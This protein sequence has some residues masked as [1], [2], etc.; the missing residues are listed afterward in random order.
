MSIKKSPLKHNE[1]VPERVDAHDDLTQEQHDKIHGGDASAIVEEE[2]QKKPWEF[3][4]PKSD[5]ED[6]AQV[7]END[8]VV[9]DVALETDALTVVAPLIIDDAVID[10]WDME[11]GYLNL[12]D[13]VTGDLLSDPQTQVYQDVVVKGQDAEAQEE[14]KDY[15]AGSY[16]EKSTF[17]AKWND[18]EGNYSYDLGGVKVKHLEN[19]NGSVGWDTFRQLS[20]S[21]ETTRNVEKYVTDNLNSMHQAYK[22]MRTTEVNPNGFDN[23]GHYYTFGYLTGFKGGDDE[24]IITRH[25]HF[26]EEESTTIELPTDW[27]EDGEMMWNNVY[28]RYLEFTNPMNAD[29][30]KM[31][32]EQVVFNWDKWVTDIKGADNIEDYVS[33][34]APNMYENVT[35][36]KYQP[37][38]LHTIKPGNQ[39]GGISKVNYQKGIGTYKQEFAY[40]TSGGRREQLFADGRGIDAQPFNVRYGQFEW[41]PS[42]GS[43]HW[44]EKF[45]DF[46][47][48]EYDKEGRL[49]DGGSIEKFEAY[50]YMYDDYTRGNK[51]IED[52]FYDTLGDEYSEYEDSGADVIAQAVDVVQPAQTESTNVDKQEELQEEQENDIYKETEVLENITYQDIIDEKSKTTTEILESENYKKESFEIQ[53]EFSINTQR[54][55]DALLEPHKEEIQNT[56]DVELKKEKDELNVQMNE[57]YNSFELED[58]EIINSLQEEIQA[59]LIK[60]LEDGTFDP[61]SEEQYSAEFKKRITTRYRQHVDSVKTDRQAQLDALTK[62]FNEIYNSRYQE[63]VTQ[64]TGDFLDNKTKE[65]EDLFY[66]HQS[67]FIQKSYENKS[68]GAEQLISDEVYDNVFKKLQKDGI[69]SYGYQTQKEAIDLAWRKLEVEFDKYLDEAEVDARREEFYYKAYE[70]ISLDKNNRPTS[71]A[72]KIWAEETI[73]E[74]EKL[75]DLTK[76][77]EEALSYAKKII[78]TP[79]FMSSTAVGRYFD[80]MFSREFSDLIPVYANIKAGNKQNYIRKL[81]QKPSEQLTEKEKETLILWSEYEKLQAKISEMST[82]YNAGSGTVDSFR[83]MIEMIA[84]RGLLKYGSKLVKIGGVQGR[85]FT[86]SQEV[87]DKYSKIKGISA[88]TLKVQ[89][90]AAATT[91]FLLKS[92]A[93]T[94][95]GGSGMIYENTID[96][97]TPEMAWS[98]TSSAEGLVFEIDNLGFYVGDDA[99]GNPIYEQDRGWDEAFT[100]AF[101][102]TWVEYGTERFGQFI[103]GGAKFLNK[104]LLGD[105]VWLK[106]MVLGRYARKMGLNPASANF[107][108]QIQRAGGWNGIIPEV[109]EEFMA[110]PLQNLI[111]G[112]GLLDG[113]DAKFTE[114]VLIQTGAM[115]VMFGAANKTYKF[116][117]GKRDPVYIAGLDSYSNPQDIIDAVRQAKKDG[118]LKDLKIEVSNDFFAFEE[119]YKELEGTGFEGNL[120]SK[121]LIE[122]VEDVAASIEVEAVNRLPEN[123]VKE[124]EDLTKQVEGLEEQRE[125][126]IKNNSKNKNETLEEIVKIEAEINKLNKQ[127]NKILDPVIAAVNKERSSEQYQEK[128]DA[129]KKFSEEVDPDTDIVEMESTAETAE[130]YEIKALNDIL[131]EHGIQVIRDAKTGKRVYIDTKTNTTLSLKD[132]NQI[133]FGLD[134]TQKP[135]TF[136]DINQQV[137]DNKNDFDATHGFTTQTVDG[138]QSIIINKEASLKLGAKNVAAH[139]FLHRFLNKTFSKNPHLKLAVGRAL[140]TQ[141]MSMNPNGIRNS[142]FR[143]RVLDYQAKQG[144]VISAEET[145][146]LFSDAL[147]KGEMKYNETFSVKVSD[148][149]RRAFSRGGKRVEFESGMDVMN[150]IRDYNKMI[151]TK[152]MSKGMRRTML[153]GAKVGGVI[154]YGSDQYAKTLRSLGLQ[155]DDQ[156]QFPLMSKEASDRVQKIYEEQGV[157][158]AFDIIDAFKPITSKLVE[159]RRN[160]P[161]FDRQLLMDEIETGARG[162]YDLI[163][164]YKSE[165]GVPLAAYI[166]KY[167][168]SRAIEASNRVLGEEFTEDITERVDVAE[169][170]VGL[171]ETFD[172]TTGR[173]I[174]LSERLG[175]IAIDINK[176]VKALASGLDM[177][178]LNFKTLKD[179]TPELTQELFGIIPKTGNLTKQDIKNAQMFINKHA[180][181]LIQMLPEGSTV[182]GTSTGVQ[183]V[184]LDAFYTKSGRAK[185]AKTGTKAGL[186]VQVKNDNI[187]TQEFLEVF[188]ITE[189]GKPNLYKK[190]SNTSSR[191]KALV[192]QT[193]KMLTNQAVREHL[194]KRQESIDIIQRISDGKS[195]IMFSNEVTGKK[196]KFDGTVDPTT[197]KLMYESKLGELT[198]A[199][200]GIE[201]RVPTKQVP[202][203]DGTF[204]TARDLDAIYSKETGE[205]FREAGARVINTF[206]QSHPEFRSL[207]RNTLT[208]G[209]KGGFFLFANSKDKAFK[210]YQ[211]ITGDNTNFDD[212]V[213]EVDAEQVDVSRW[214]YNTKVKGIGPVFNR[215]KFDILK[216]AKFKND[217]AKRLDVLYNFFS[218]VESH[219]QN[220]PN[221]IWMF[222]EMLLDTGKHQNTLTRVLAPFTFY[223]INPKTKK[224]V[225]NKRAVEEHTDPQNLIGKALLT[226]A[227]FSKVDDVWKVVGKSYMQGSLLEVDDPSGVLKSNMPDIYYEMV[228]P[229]LLSGELNLPNGYS[230][231]IRLAVSGIDPNAYMLVDSNKTIAEFFNVTNMPI[232][233]ANDLII[234]Q[235]TGEIKPEYVT[236][237]SKAASKIPAKSEINKGFMFSR[238]VNNSRKINHKTPSRGMS[239]FDFDETLIDKGKNIIIAKK[240]DEILEITSAQWP[241]QGPALA[242]AGYEFDFSDFINV[243]GGVEG[244]LMQKFRNRIKK[245]GIENNY[246]LTARPQES[247]PAIQAWLKQQGINLPI[248]N[249]TGLGNSTGEAKALWIVEKYSQGYNDIYFVDD[250]LPNVKAVADVIDQLDIK[251]SSVQAKINFSKDPSKDFNDILERTTKVKSEKIFSDVQARIRGRKGRYKSL[252][253]PSAQDFAGLL[254]NF[255]GRGKIGEEQMAFFKRTLIDPFAR[256]I[257]ELNAAKQTSFNDLNNLYKEFKGIKKRLRRKIPTTSFTQDQAVRVYLWNKAG[258]EIPGI[259]KRDLKTLVSWIEKNPRLQAFADALGLISKKE[260][261]YAKPGEYWIVESIESDLLSDGAIGDV[262]STFLAEWIQNKNIIFSPENLNKIEAIYGSKFREA[263]EDMLYRMETGSNRPRGANRITNAYMNWVNNSVGAI[264]F[265]NI[266]SAVLQTI[267]AT[268]YINWTDNNPYKAGLA[269]ANQRQFWKDFVYIFNSDMLKTRRRGNQRGVQESE[270]MKAVVGSS[271]PIKAALAWLLNKGFLPTQIADSFAIGFGGASFYRNRVKTYLKQGLNQKEAQSRAWLDFQ[272]T[273]EVSQQSARPDLIS[274]QQANPLGRLILAFQNTPMQYGRIMNKS[275]RDIV[276]GRGDMKT[277]LSK[278][279][280]YGAVQAIIF[281]ALQSAIWASLG[282]EDEEKFDQKK[283]RILNGIFE[284][285]LSAFGYGGKA[286]G[287]LK[288]SIEEYLKQRDKGWN[289]DHA[290]TLLALLSFSPPI[291]SKLRKIYSSIQTD[292]FNKDIFMKR[293]FTLDNPLWQAIGHTIEGFTNIP[294]GRLSNKMLNLD[295]AMDSNNE[296]WQRVALIMGWNTWDL[297][298]RDVDIETLKLEVKEQKKQEKKIEKEEKKRIKEE[299]EEQ[300]EV[301]QVEK[302]KELQKKEREEGKKV[303]CAA[304]NK[305]GKRCG[306]KVEGGGAF[307]TIHEEVEQR[308]SGEKTQCKGIKSDKKRCKMMT[309]ASS[310][311]CYYHD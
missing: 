270:L 24:L 222:E 211:K 192:S 93:M 220:F 212:F 17:D 258:F 195:R 169:E 234:K 207:L 282:D 158:G 122:V 66:K 231:I 279:V 149:L 89:N 253:P 254:Y 272:E 256:G 65:L 206:L 99:D 31:A 196:S 148:M 39:R 141:L 215:N 219:L 142:E 232:E 83:F 170:T 12:D 298:I 191:V 268:N 181:T 277:H 33:K 147:V 307:C 255:L 229:R 128:V 209:K 198:R 154:K 88:G 243:R 236:H 286:V 135:I 242:E 120:T 159:R 296:W 151:E 41:P 74:L 14:L 126:L 34:I 259:S 72:M 290:Y 249:I 130:F 48:P 124:V 84:S 184:L 47:P 121:N 252:I 299:K 167:L 125:T 280:Y 146:N 23:N 240:G 36:S 273:T 123:K 294:L 297:G 137:Q 152:R 91:D 303:K 223:P 295:N 221:D 263:L 213:E 110:Q 248:E 306:K 304:V 233:T 116:A 183:K 55:L 226:G 150:F 287:T 90:T 67:E 224:P 69:S 54:E 132:L 114:E 309:S 239:A 104:Q 59:Q 4:S 204:Y 161:G 246:I 247:A 283:E 45:T 261:G 155:Q 131:S 302:N 70:K 262:R 118:T 292:R 284:G 133:N 94:T 308:E 260:D 7:V 30:E 105:P 6:E 13:N 42:S 20:P 288:R 21:D 25:G 173:K 171:V 60:E 64:Y 267:S 188:G 293:G 81:L 136:Q 127:K 301:N 227:V 140:E 18:G 50:E 2:E 28:K 107:L 92:A 163:Q 175:G 228:V 179:L 205:T 281:N 19:L 129:V 68:N 22:E 32:L 100:K 185:M 271:N 274:Q 101:G 216:T 197:Y 245:Y 62:P 264:M 217:R 180:A 276:N 108:Q 63:L 300:E 266:R 61:I 5:T 102:S 46:I 157:G 52:L 87:I 291:G 235:L 1:K 160:A 269:F 43:Y 241:I 85:L 86:K 178:K 230:S 11:D 58:E 103:P 113:I 51:V 106:R 75:D 27:S 194:I 182:S 187:S 44:Y 237:F 201:K 35:G 3:K 80:G 16:K 95:V 166:N 57:L 190:D 193:G 82:S 153:K 210:N 202:K 40:W 109:M 139:E 177:S 172:Q 143:A 29:A 119:I 56:L 165:S 176:Q 26:G 78:E 9:E 186:A 164:E 203:G 251:G 134:D 310:G 189:R 289:S 97:M 15:E 278:L 285:W 238:A 257:N 71:T 111:D 138:K 115:Q 265:F 214:I 200:S 144:D 38:G 10:I 79:E 250:A 77:E 53:A 218:A 73:A 8:I 311:Y 162:I 117:T 96:R 37:G 275:I 76:S 305:S 112:R 225:F 98:L 145:L 174:M 168:P 244:P 49:L 156:G 199:I 208:G